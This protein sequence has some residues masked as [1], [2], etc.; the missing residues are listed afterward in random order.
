[1]EPTQPSS[2]P[3]AR[4][5]VVIVL[6]C[7]LA[8][9]AYLVW[10]NYYRMPVSTTPSATPVASSSTQTSSLGNDIYSQPQELINSGLPQTNPFQ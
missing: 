2:K 4:V 6:V 9:V 7:V 3:L 8:A 5:V 1:M 10:D